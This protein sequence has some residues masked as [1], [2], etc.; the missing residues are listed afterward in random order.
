M[1]NIISNPINSTVAIAAE[2]L[3]AAGVYDP[4]KLIGPFFVV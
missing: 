2:A 4:K 3:K 1:L